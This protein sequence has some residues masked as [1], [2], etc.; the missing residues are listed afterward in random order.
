LK[1]PPADTA[2]PAAFAMPRQPPFSLSHFELT[3][4]DYFHF[5]FI[6]DG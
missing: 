3:A 4:A 2:A 5:H 1:L 6:A